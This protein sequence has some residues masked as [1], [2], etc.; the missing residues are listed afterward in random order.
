MFTADKRDLVIRQII[1]AV[2][3]G[4]FN[5]KVE[6]DDPNLSPQEKHRIVQEF[7]NNLQKIGYKISN[8][9]ARFLAGRLTKRLNHD[10]I[11]HGEQN[12]QG[13]S[14]GAIVTSNHFHPTDNSAVRWALKKAGIK[15]LYVVSQESNLAMKGLIGFLM[16]YADIIPLTKNREDMQ[17]YFS[18]LL[19]KHLDEGQFVL[20]YPEEEMWF[21]Y[22]KPRPPKR[23][24]YYYAAENNVPIVSCFVIIHDDRSHKETKE[25]YETKFEVEILK[26]IYPKPELS[27]RENSRW[28]MGQDY[29]QKVEAYERAYGKKLDYTF[30]KSDIAGWIPEIESV[31]EEEP[32]Q[33][34]DFLEEAPEQT[35][36]LEEVTHA[37]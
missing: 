28:M 7:L 24:A 31:V 36:I 34:E 10:T 20:I 19:K 17:E 6:V 27:V 9:V 2:Q 33:E 8:G 23:G 32:L 13:I 25:L 22:R 30:D 4:R 18:K 21:N 15:R 29:K 35:I 37:I 12:V 26:P 11:V 14:K 1:K 16:N 5:D 3:E